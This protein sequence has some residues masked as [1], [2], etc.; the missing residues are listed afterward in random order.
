MKLPPNKINTYK[1]DSKEIQMNDEGYEVKITSFSESYIPIIADNNDISELKK[2]TNNTYDILLFLEDLISKLE[3]K[4]KSDIKENIQSIISN[5]KKNDKNILLSN[6]IMT[7]S[8]LNIKKNKSTQNGGSKKSKS[9][10]I[11]GIRYLSNNDIFLKSNTREILDLPNSLSSFSDNLSEKSELNRYK[12]SDDDDEKRSKSNNNYMMPMSSNMNMGMSTNM[13]MPMVPNM[14][15]PMIPNMQMP[16]VPNMQMPMAQMGNYA[17]NNQITTDQLVK[18]G[19]VPPIHG[20][21]MPKTSA[22]LTLRPQNS[23]NGGA[24]NG[25]YYIDIANPV[26]NFF[27]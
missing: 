15:M 27:F 14:Q 8:F 2:E 20:L 22:D 18:L 26:N 16:M 3:D 7:D 4:S 9:R 6:I 25:E 23:M 24:S 11:K 12:F 5:I 1:L 13:Q 10:V 21:N 19:M 17:G